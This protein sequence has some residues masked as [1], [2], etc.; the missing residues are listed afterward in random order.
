MQQGSVH[1][2][3]RSS[4]VSLARMGRAINAEI[5]W[6]SSTSIG[7]NLRIHSTAR[8]NERRGPP[9]PVYH[10]QYDPAALVAALK[11]LA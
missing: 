4:T 9:A 11:T 3:A 2:F 6:L 10:G 1:Q 7:Q 8:P 5:A